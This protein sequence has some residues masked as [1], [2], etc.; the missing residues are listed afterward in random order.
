[1]KGS[2]KVGTIGEQWFVVELG[3]A[4]DFADSAMPSVLSTLHSRSSQASSHLCG[5]IRAARPAQIRA[6]RLIRAQ[7]A[8][9]DGNPLQ[10]LALRLRWRCPR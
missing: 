2:P 9:L 3:H 7:M 5:P 6:N 8:M 10:P 4:I 1:M